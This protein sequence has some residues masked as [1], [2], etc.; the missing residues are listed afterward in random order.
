M[1]ERLRSASEARARRGA[2]GPRKRA[3]EGV[4]RDE[5]PRY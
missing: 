4:R 2:A 5:V 1:S 3:G